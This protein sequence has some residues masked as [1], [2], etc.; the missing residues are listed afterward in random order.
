MRLF[1]RRS[2][3]PITDMSVTIKLCQLVVGVTGD[4]PMLTLSY[5]VVPD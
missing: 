4:P 3:E 5:M 2:G 1:Y